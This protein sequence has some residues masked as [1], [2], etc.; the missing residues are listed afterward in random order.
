MADDNE[1]LLRQ[2]AV[3]VAIIRTK[4]EEQ[5][6]LKLAQ[7]VA[8]LEKYQNILLGGMILINFALGAFAVLR[9]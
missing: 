9:K 8:M 4:L 2:M 6:K 3:D 7:R 1:T 5:E